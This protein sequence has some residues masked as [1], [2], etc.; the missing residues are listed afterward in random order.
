M[1]RLPRWLGPAGLVVAFTL[2]AAW[3]WRKWSDPVI[4]FGLDPYIAW[5]LTSGKV[6]YADIA[7]RNGPLSQYLNA[8]WFWLFGVSLRTLVLVN[9]ACLVAI[10]SLVFSQ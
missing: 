3:S 6:L 2:L 4:D 9:L 5:Q 7:Y 10:C 8:L 1:E